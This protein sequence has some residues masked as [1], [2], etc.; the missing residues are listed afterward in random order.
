MKNLKLLKQK[1][2][3]KYFKRNFKLLYN[4]K[5]D[6]GILDLCKIINI[7]P[8]SILEI[9]C[10]NGIRLHEYQKTLMSRINYG[11]D[12]S[13]LAIKDGK[14]RYKKLKLIRLSSLDLS[15][16][17][18][19]FDLI[20]CGFF[21]YMLDSEEIFNQF[22][23]IYKK[24]NENGHL[25]IEDFDPLF[26]HTNNSIYNKN[27]KSFKMNYDRF[28]EE[29]GLFKTVY[30][31]RQNNYFLDKKKLKKNKTRKNF[32]SQDVSITLLKKINF[33]DSFPVNI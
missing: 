5:N 2:A 20:I 10:A 19:K 28:L 1:E 18:I 15:K 25:I 31:L 30:K 24:L 21:L 8:K 9:G 3:N 22:N 14:K 26:K 7:K 4:T 11:I 16:I 29:S 27:L 17:K 33:E 6:N 32:K 13:S 12:I 23:L